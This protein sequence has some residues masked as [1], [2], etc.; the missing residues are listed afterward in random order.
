MLPPKILLPP[1]FALANGD[2]PNALVGDVAAWLPKIDAVFALLPAVLPPKMLCAG[3]AAPPNI[4][5]VGCVA[6]AVDEAGADNPKLANDSAV[7]VAFAPNT[8]DAGD[9]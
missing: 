5:P 7:S 4:L 8:F 2:A 9:C 3:F 6:L 1:V